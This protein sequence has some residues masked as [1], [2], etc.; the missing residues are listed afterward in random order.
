MH[1]LQEKVSAAA[2]VGA[3]APQRCPA[4]TRT[5]EGVLMQS[6]SN[7]IHFEALLPFPQ[8]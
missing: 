5:L 3:S 8:T 1:K 2:T 7:V 6:E 4:D